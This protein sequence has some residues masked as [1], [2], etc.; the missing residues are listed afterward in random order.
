VLDG[1]GAWWSGHSH[2][3]LG[4]SWMGGNVSEWVERGL[5]ADLVV[6]VLVPAVASDTVTFPDFCRTRSAASFFLLWCSGFQLADPR[7]LS[8]PGR[9]RTGVL[10]IRICGAIL[11]LDVFQFARLGRVR[12]FFP[13][14]PFLPLLTS[15]IPQ[16]LTLLPR[17]SPPTNTPTAVSCSLPLRARLARAPPLLVPRRARGAVW[18]APHGARGQ[19]RGKGHRHVVW[20]Q[21]GGGG[22]EVG[23]L[24]VVLYSP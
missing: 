2:P 3:R 15:P 8:A 7:A 9:P 17:T 13:L 11:S 6:W 1:E 19:G 24:H 23:N 12:A 16:P 14:T 18:R 4:T 21:R 22:I 20:S 10:D 5:E